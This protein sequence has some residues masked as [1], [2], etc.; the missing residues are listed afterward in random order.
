MLSA[1]LDERARRIGRQI[2]GKALAEFAQHIVDDSAAFG[3]TRRGVNLVERR[4]AQHVLGV[5]RVRVAQPVLDF[6]NR[7]A[8][9]PRCARR[10]WRRPRL[11]FH[12]LRPVEAA[13]PGEIDVASLERRLPSALAGHSAEA[14]DKTRRR[15]GRAA[16]LGGAREKHFRSAEHLREVVR[17]QPDATLGQIETELHAHRTAEPGVSSAFRRPRPFHEFAKHDA[18]VRR[19]SRFQKAE[20]ANA[21]VATGR[22]A[23]HPVG[24][25]RGEKLDIIGRRNAKRC[26]SF[27]DRE[28]IER[29]GELGAVRAGEGMFAPT[30]PLTRPRAY[31]DGARQFR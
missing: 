11:G 10:L 6:G 22:P 16:D 19:Q 23:H 20:D 4:Q 14:L 27:A 18:I 17:G 1:H 26:R 9:G 21:R 3:G 12:V 7:E 13:R 31:H 15:S 24:K 29:V 28:L 5:D 25:H 30:V 8:L 2:A